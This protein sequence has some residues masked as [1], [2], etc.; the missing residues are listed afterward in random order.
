MLKT[1]PGTQKALRKCEF[2]SGTS[3]TTWCST[4]TS[5]VLE[6][7]ATELIHIPWALK[8]EK[9]SVLQD[10]KGLLP[11]TGCVIWGWGSGNRHSVPPMP[12]GSCVTLDWASEAFRGLS[13]TVK[14]GDNANSEGLWNDYI[15]DTFEKASKTDSHRHKCALLF[16]S[17]GTWP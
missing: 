17:L 6:P 9:G 13:S 7:G 11:F 8:S 15:Y 4:N 12:L 16:P 5:P 1:G 2:L 3:N 14:N 10:G